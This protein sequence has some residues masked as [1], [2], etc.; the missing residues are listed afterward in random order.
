[1]RTKHYYLAR[2]GGGDPEAMGQSGERAR[3]T[4]M[5][6]VIIGTASVAAISMFFA[7]HHAVG[8]DVGWSIP[9]ALGWGLLILII[10]RF[11]VISMN[12]TRGRPW[13]LLGML[14]LR[15]VLA[16]LIATVVSMPIVLQIFSS[17][18]NAELPIIAAQKSAQ[19]N[20]SLTKSA[21]GKSLA[22][23]EG[24]ITTEQAVASGAVSSKVK[25]DQ[26][27]VNN[28][29]TQLSNAENTAA[30]AGQKYACEEDGDKGATAGC[31]PGTSGRAGD[32]SRAQA[33]YAA[34]QQDLSEVSSIKGELAKASAQLTADENASNQSVQAAQRELT[35]LR[36]E[37]TSLQNT[38]N[39]QIAADNA[40]NSDDTGLLAQIQALFAASDQS[41]G[42]TIAHWVVT[43]LFFVIELLP[44]LVKT[45]LL[46]G[47][48][49][50]HDRIVALREEA[51][52]EDA[53]LAI[54]EE[55]SA[56]HSVR[57]AARGLREAQDQAR[58]AMRQR[59]LEAEIAVAQGKAKNTEDAEAHMRHRELDNRIKVQDEVAD[60]SY[61]Y[62]M[63]IVGEWLES[64]RARFRRDPPPDAAGNGA[65][66]TGHG[67]NGSGP[68]EEPVYGSAPN[69]ES[70]NGANGNGAVPNGHQPPTDEWRF[71][72]GHTTPDGDG[73]T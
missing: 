28:L 39:G 26:D 29:N 50:L 15:L 47:K 56:A 62:A 27:Q 8:A 38:I 68:D 17:D 72:P 5:G 53:R 44:V 6:C 73:I 43:G 18:I 60:G 14:L 41:T 61:T 48:E 4:S 51:A 45:M 10:D 36:G 52:L 22:K 57:Q 31:P 33:D 2:L 69:G 58:L 40:K 3:F 13:Q 70:L 32:G 63:G 46:L 30:T 7:L 34:W 59:E 24:E 9:I 65:S 54:E 37:E 66:G 71:L 23:V 12:G 1:M 55:R 11:M 21:T 25:A 20:T 16:G 35:S 67:P 19:Y 64:I 42:L 49:S